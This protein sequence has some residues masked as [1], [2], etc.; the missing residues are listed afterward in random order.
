MARTSRGAEIISPPIKERVHPPPLNKQGLEPEPPPPSNTLNKGRVSIPMDGCS[1]SPAD[2][3]QGE[4]GGGRG[5]GEQTGP[6]HASSQ[7]LSLSRR[8]ARV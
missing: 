1:A 2:G 7:L 8:A 6:P 3:K 4:L 5:G